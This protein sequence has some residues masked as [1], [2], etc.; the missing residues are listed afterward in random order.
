MSSKKTDIERQVDAL[1]RRKWQ[2]LQYS[3]WYAIPISTL[4]QITF[5]EHTIVPYVIAIPIAIYSAYKLG[6]FSA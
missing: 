5:H 1:V 4:A 3:V 2:I 6:R